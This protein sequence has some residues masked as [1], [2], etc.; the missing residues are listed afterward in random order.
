VNHTPFDP[1]QRPGYLLWQAAHALDHN[2]T[3]ALAPF[4]VTLLQFSCLVHITN[5]PGVSAAEL[6]RRTGITPQSVQTSLKPL[7][8]NGTIERRAH[9][10]HGR[11]LGIH[12]SDA[13]YEVVL[14]AGGVVDSVEDDLVDGFSAAEAEQLHNLLLRALTNLNPVTLDRSSIRAQ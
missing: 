4:G 12:P 10:I 9:P 3:T 7:L 11:V 1:V 14:K 2:L 13:A 8:A 5:E 6:S